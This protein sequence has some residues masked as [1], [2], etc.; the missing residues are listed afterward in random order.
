MTLKFPACVCKV[1]NGQGVSVRSIS[2]ID[3]IDGERF[4]ASISQDAGLVFP[5]DY[6]RLRRV[7]ETRTPRFASPTTRDFLPR[8]SN[9]I[10]YLV[11]NRELESIT[12]DI[13]S[14]NVRMDVSSQY[15]ARETTSRPRVRVLLTQFHRDFSIIAAMRTRVIFPRDFPS[16]NFTYLHPR[17][18]RAE[19]WHR[20]IRDRGK[21]KSGC[22]SGSISFSPKTR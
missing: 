6:D 2:K 16:S 3:L 1:R 4:L 20:L 22:L 18:A 10:D 14:N 5:F 8:F 15:L 21:L 9:R 13:R 17:R 7:S 11:A 19:S 12:A